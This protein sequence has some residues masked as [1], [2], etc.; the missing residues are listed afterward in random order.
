MEKF[1][2]QNCQNSAHVMQKFCYQ[3]GLASV[4]HTEEKRKQVLA[5]CEKLD[6]M[7]WDE[8]KREY[9]CECSKSVRLYDKRRHEKENE[10]HLDYVRLMSTPL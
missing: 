8:F 2:C 5:E 1:F 7:R 6:K 10:F 3:C 4:D 9:T